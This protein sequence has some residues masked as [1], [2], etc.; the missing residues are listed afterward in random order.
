MEHVVALVFT[1]RKLSS[2]VPAAPFPCCAVILSCWGWQVATVA[3]VV[4]V[5]DEVV[6]AAVVVVVAGADVV[7]MLADG[8]PDEHPARRSP[9]SPRVAPPVTRRA[10]RAGRCRR[11]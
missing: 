2:I 6:V 9:R 4:D 11:L 8:L 1:M 5:D 10:A 3:A 7:V